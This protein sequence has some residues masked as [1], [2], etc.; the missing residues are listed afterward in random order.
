M[1]VKITCTDTLQDGKTYEFKVQSDYK[2]NWRTLPDE[3][4]LLTN[5]ASI[6]Y[7]I[8]LCTLDTINCPWNSDF[9]YYNAAYWQGPDYSTP[10]LLSHFVY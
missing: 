9:I 8:V 4:I 6:Y 2:P 7:D 3:T 10:V 1:Q 5:S